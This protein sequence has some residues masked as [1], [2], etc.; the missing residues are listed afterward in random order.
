[1]NTPEWLIPGLVVAALSGVIV[2]AF[3]VT[4]VGWTTGAQADAMAQESVMR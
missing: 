1:M 2:V 4:T 3:G